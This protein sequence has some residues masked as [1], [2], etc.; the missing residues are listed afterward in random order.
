MTFTF[1]C[2]FFSIALYNSQGE[3]LE[4]FNQLLV[5]C[6][7]DGTSCVNG[8]CAV[9]VD[10]SRDEALEAFT[11]FNGRWYAGRQLSCRF[12]C[13]SRW[14]MAICGQSRQPLMIMSLILTGFLCILESLGMF[15][16]L[17][18]R[19]LL[20]CHAQRTSVGGFMN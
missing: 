9:S 7:V 19:P 17:I 15:F 1:F 20:A 2:K 18:L 5:D 14:K 4:T 12:T 8:T 16:S 13:V 10:N 3:T 11:K 6:M